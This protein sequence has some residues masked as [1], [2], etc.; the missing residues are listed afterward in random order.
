LPHDA[1]ERGRAS[2]VD[3]E[4]YGVHPVLE[5]LRARRR[6]L[7]RVLLRKGSRRPEFE[8]IRAAAE[9]AGVPIEE[10]RA[11]QLASDVPPGATTQGV[12][13][14][15]GPLP[16]VLLESLA[17]GEGR[18]TLVALDGVEDPQNVGAIARVAEAAGAAGLLLTRRHAPPLGAAVSRAS[19]GAIEWLPTARVPNLGRALNAL[20]KQG[21]W[22][23][24]CAPEATEDLFALPERSLAQATV[25]VLGAEGRGLRPGILRT[26][27]HRVR[28]PM[29]GR[30][31]SLNV[32]AAAAVVLFELRRRVAPG[33]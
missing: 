15:A 23:F 30:V 3:V 22:V 6:P 29:A 19:A 26:L 25:V 1:R 32:A 31:G 21:F 14:R 7:H 13:L 4:L 8:R 18:R 17:T 16:E 33:P 11:E 24:G 27:D 12:L 5:A 28:I 2:R 10:R 9:A 20:K